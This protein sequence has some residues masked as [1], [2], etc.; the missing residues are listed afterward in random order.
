MKTFTV[1]ALVLGVGL[2]GRADDKKKTEAP[3]LAGNYS[4]VDGKKNG[5]KVGDDAKKGK[6]VIDDKK[7]TTGD[8]DGKFVFSYKLDGTKIDME[9]LEAP[10]EGLKGSKGYGIIEVKG[11]TLKLAYNTEKDKRPKNFE[12]KEGNYFELKKDKEKAKE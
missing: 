4:L 7:I 2:L 11:D 3:K 1:L 10:F 8:K 5:E 9:I 6:Y 12:G